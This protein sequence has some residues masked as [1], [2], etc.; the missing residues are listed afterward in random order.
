M[1]ATP[2]RGRRDW[3][4]RVEPLRRIGPAIRIEGELARADAPLELSMRVEGL[5]PV[6]GHRLVLVAT[7]IPQRSAS[8]RAAR[9]R[10][11]APTAQGSSDAS[12]EPSI[13]RSAARPAATVSKPASTATAEA[14]GPRS[15]TRPAGASKNIGAMTRK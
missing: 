3:Q 10:S 1:A 12:S 14:A 4:S 15:A 5:E 7:M 9:S 13:T 8:A 11:D 2:K 6:E